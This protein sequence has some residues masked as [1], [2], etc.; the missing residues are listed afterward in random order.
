MVRV[1]QPEKSVRR[2][3]LSHRIESL[4]GANYRWS[5][6][7]H[8]CSPARTATKPTMSRG[9]PLTQ[10]CSA[11]RA[12]RIDGSRSGTQDVCRVGAILVLLLCDS[13]P[14][15]TESRHVQQFTLKVSPVQINYAP[16]GES[17]LYV[18][19]GNQLF[20]M[21]YGKDPDDPAA[22]AQWSP[23][24]RASV[25]ALLS[26]SL[27][28]SPDGPTCASTADGINRDVQ[29]HGRQRDSHAHV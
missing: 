12:R 3:L 23:M 28:V 17:L 20:F 29:P 16:D 19:S 21:S 26:L 22:Q 27:C 18:S 13:P 9:I 2:W 14:S 11:P 10:S 15:R 1:F 6:G 24:N 8:P 5:R 7:R 4:I 25:R